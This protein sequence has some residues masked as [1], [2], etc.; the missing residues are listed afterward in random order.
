MIPLSVIDF[1]TTSS[2]FLGLFE[3]R[4][5][6]PFVIRTHILIYVLFSEARRIQEVIELSHGDQLFHSLL[7]F[8]LIQRCRNV[9]QGGHIVVFD[10][11]YVNLNDVFHID[12]VNYDFPWLYGSIQFFP[13][14]SLTSILLI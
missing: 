11:P 12:P 1:D 3:Q 2:F 13:G 14:H 9:R 4:L 10:K 8:I 7:V 6:S 5:T